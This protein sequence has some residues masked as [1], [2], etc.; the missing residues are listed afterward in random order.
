MVLARPVELV[1]DGVERAG[2]GSKKIVQIDAQGDLTGWGG[3]TGAIVSLW[4]GGSRLRFAFPRLKPL[5]FWEPRIG[6]ALRARLTTVLA[7]HGL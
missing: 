2:D 6:D 4:G 7:S 5:R 3:M 1:L